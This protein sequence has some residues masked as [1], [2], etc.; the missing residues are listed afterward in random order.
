MD[1]SQFKDS[2][3]C[4]G[5]TG[6]DNLVE[7]VSM[8]ESPVASKY[9]KGH[10]LVMTSGYCLLDDEEMQRQII[11]DLVKTGAAG[12]AITLMFYDHKLPEVMR[13]TA[14]KHG[15]PVISIPDDI[16][17][18]D[19]YELITANFFSS[20]SKAVK[21]KV[22]VFKEIDESIYKEGLMGAAKLLHRWTGL[23][24]VVVFDKQKFLV[25]MEETE[26]KIPLQHSE[27][28]EKKSEKV[29]KLQVS[30]YS[31]KNG[32]DTIQWLGS[33]INS[34]KQ[35]GAYVQLLKGE[36][37]FT[38]DD[39]ELVDHTST[40]CATEIKRLKNSMELQR[41]YH[42]EFFKRFFEG[43]YTTEDA[44]HQAH[45][46]GF[47]LPEKSVVAI[48]DFQDYVCEQVRDYDSRE[49]FIAQL[50]RIIQTIFGKNTLYHM[51]KDN[52]VLLYIPYEPEEKNQR[53]QGLYTMLSEEC[54]ASVRIGLSKPLQYDAIRK[55]INEAQNAI[56]IGV[57]LKLLP[58]IYN[59]SELGFYRLLNL[60]EAQSE[61]E[62]YY[63]EYLKPI[64][65]YD[66]MN[67]TQLLDTL[68][69]YIDNNYNYKEA[70]N[71]MF[72]HPNT[73]RYRVG[74]IEK[75]CRINLNLQYDRFNIEVALKLLPLINSEEHT[76]LI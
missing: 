31:L 35:V 40:A 28:K 59:F 37:E 45:K 22:E 3:V 60:P 23:P 39:Y 71:S 51:P 57:H 55:G 24:A 15:F 5:E 13:E 72:I 6:L 63:Q 67:D 38:E 1:C 54:G 14:E 10:E 50:G 4:A 11:K 29:F 48:L 47:E 17:Y 53:I 8:W 46:M 7:T 33:S 19:I 34:V 64:I 74:V 73:A 70:A 68:L 21:R 16:Y 52:R 12:L 30:P 9:I 42:A 27:W 32:K 18:T 76:N 25:G 62:S 56:Q 61:I 66:T 43:A 44:I 2:V 58:N 69:H 26:Y 20:V 65:E 41:K 75:I 49:S 36:R